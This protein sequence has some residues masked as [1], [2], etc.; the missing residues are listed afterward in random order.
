MRLGPRFGDGAPT[1]NEA[2]TG[3][4]GL[5]LLTSTF[6]LGPG[7]KG[8]LGGPGTGPSTGMADPARGRGRGGP[9]YGPSGPG[10]GYGPG[11]WPGSRPGT[12]F[13]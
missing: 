1:T 9:G 6:D 12:A 8:A 13:N 5:P 2:G 11:S 10:T 3:T 7:S 4:S